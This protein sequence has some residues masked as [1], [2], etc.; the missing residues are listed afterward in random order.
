MAS[1]PPKVL[2]S[3]SHDST[4]HA[5]RVLA[6]ADQ[7]R[8]DGIEVCIDQYVRDPEEGWIKWM[9][10]Q[11]KQAEKVLLVFTKTCQKRFVGD[12]EEGKSLAQRSN[13]SS[14]PKR[15]TRAA[16]V[17]RSFDH[18]LFQYLCSSPNH[19]IRTNT[20]PPRCS[21]YDTGALHA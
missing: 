15:G 10:T 12:E 11:V 17:T 1:D 9:R 16:G 14:L 7:L 19:P 2:I 5:Q 13:V 6:L 20:G 18:R 4:E 3:Y 21:K 8:A